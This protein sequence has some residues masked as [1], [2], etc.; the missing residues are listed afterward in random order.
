[1][2]GMIRFRKE[3]GLS[4][5]S[6]VRGSDRLRSQERENK[7]AEKVQTQGKAQGGRNSQSTLADV[8]RIIETKALNKSLQTW[9]R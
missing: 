9:L 5:T 2:I 1:M 8:Q 6:L 4:I 3:I 7:L